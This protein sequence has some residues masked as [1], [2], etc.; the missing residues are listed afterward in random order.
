[1]NYRWFSLPLALLMLTTALESAE[2]ESG[3]DGTVTVGPTHG[4]PIHEGESD[5]KPLAAAPFTVTNDQGE[6][7]MTF[8]TDDKGHFAVAL[9]SGHYTVSYN[10][11][12][13]GIRGFGPFQVNVEREKV[14]KVEW[15][16]DTGMR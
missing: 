3:I 2:H 16:A 13:I 1:M 15:R 9:Q 4:G 10:G 7:V 12:R 8:R 11:E 14:T 6:R 5:S